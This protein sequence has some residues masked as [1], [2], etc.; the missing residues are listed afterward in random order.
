MSKC[1]ELV[2]DLEERRV[3]CGE[4][5]L[6]KKTYSEKVIS[7]TYSYKTGEGKCSSFIQRSH[8]WIP[9]NQKWYC[10]NCG[11]VVEFRNAKCPSCGWKIIGE[12]DEEN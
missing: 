11:Y 6:S 4:C 12:T 2:M 5:M 8:E 9:I 1:G 7:C 10:P 3:E